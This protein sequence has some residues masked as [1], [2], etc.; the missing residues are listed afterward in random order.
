VLGR[1][2]EATWVILDEDLS[3]AHAEIRRGWDGVT[4][5]D[6]GSR[7]GTRVGGARITAPTSL[8]DG[9]VVELG[10]TQLRFDDPA[11]RHLRGAPPAVRVP[12]A[13]PV[14]APA[15]RAEA[16]PAS[17]ATIAVAVLIAALAA[18]GLVWILST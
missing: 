4:V 14:V 5:A 6:L 11:E 9:D 16:P 18:I 1:G 8:H 2:D 7:N 12:D 17:Q 13:L 15:M 10:R 3:R